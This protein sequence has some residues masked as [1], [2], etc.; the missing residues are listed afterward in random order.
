MLFPKVFGFHLFGFHLFG[1]HLLK[2]RVRVCKYPVGLGKA[3][4]LKGDVLKTEEYK[5][6][7]VVILLRRHAFGLLIPVACAFTGYA[8]GGVVTAHQFISLLN[9]GDHFICSSGEGSTQ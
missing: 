1:F 8:V 7:R 6:A 3:Q 9:D 2:M 5:R 4:G